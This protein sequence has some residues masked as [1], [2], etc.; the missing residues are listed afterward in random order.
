MNIKLS[1]IISI[2][3]FTTNLPGQSILYL[4]I[5]TGQYGGVTAVP[6]EKPFISYKGFTTNLEFETYIKSNRSVSFY[7]KYAKFSKTDLFLKMADSDAFYFG[8]GY[9]FVNQINAGNFFYEFSP[10]AAYGI[11]KINWY[12]EIGSFLFV[13][14]PK[15]I[16]GNDN[17]EY[18]LTGLQ[19]SIGYKSRK[20]VFKLS[21]LLNCDFLLYGRR[22]I[23]IDTQ[24]GEK[25]YDL[26]N[27]NYCSGLYIQCKISVGFILH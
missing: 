17:L 23:F 20:L 13:S 15:V 9:N 8:I 25:L 21:L 1:L 3:F 22:I 19:S 10:N 7:I 27:P 18:L 4:G 12:D 5:G 24:T 14:S 6:Y 11:E 26:N 2:L 16:S